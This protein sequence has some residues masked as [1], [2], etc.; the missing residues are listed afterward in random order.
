MAMIQTADVSNLML[1]MKSL[2]V[3]LVLMAC[4]VVNDPSSA[5]AATRRANWNRDGPPPFAAHC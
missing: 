3:T 5:T 2:C 4:E 1:K